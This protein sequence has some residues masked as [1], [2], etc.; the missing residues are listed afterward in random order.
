MKIEGNYHDKYSCKLC[1]KIKKKL[2]KENKKQILREFACLWSDKKN[3]GNC[4][5]LFDLDLPT[6]R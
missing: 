4:S 2:V 5:W 1:V 6:A 3:N